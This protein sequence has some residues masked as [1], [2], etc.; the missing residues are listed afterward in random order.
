MSPYHMVYLGSFLVAFMNAVLE[1]SLLPV[2]CSHE[3]RYDS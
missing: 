3:I 2:C 1:L